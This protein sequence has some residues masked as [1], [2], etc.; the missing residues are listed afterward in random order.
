MKFR[1]FLFAVLI[2]IQPLYAQTQLINNL[3]AGR[4]QTVVIY[5][6]SLSSGGNGRAWMGEV[7]RQLNGKYGSSG[8]L[9]IRER[10]YV[11]HLGSS[12]P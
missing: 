4:D 3:K 6:T 2:L 9:F 7:A 11:V 10:R 12:T 8:L 1:F 5:G